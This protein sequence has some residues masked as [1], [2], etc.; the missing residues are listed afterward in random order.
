MIDVTR[1]MMKEST[2]RNRCTQCNLRDVEYVKTRCSDSVFLKILFALSPV[3]K[4][5]TFERW[6]G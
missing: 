2:C 3:S 6:F 1:L 5:F 4:Q